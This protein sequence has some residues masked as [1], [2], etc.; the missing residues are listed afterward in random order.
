MQSPTRLYSSDLDRKNSVERNPLSGSETPISDTSFDFDEDL[1]EQLNKSD[2]E[3][4]PDSEFYYKPDQ[5]E[6]KT[7]EI[8]QKIMFNALSK[9]E[10]G[11][12]ENF[13]Y[14]NENVETPN[15]PGQIETGESTKAFMEDVDNFL[16]DLEK[17]IKQF[18]EEIGKSDQDQEETDE[19]LKKV[20][21]SLKTVSSL[22]QSQDGSI[23]YI[24]CENFPL[25]IK[26]DKTEKRCK[27]LNHK[28]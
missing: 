20:L 26:Y 2:S 10:E 22:S 9:T 8:E 24:S 11:H 13:N 6:Y 25:L 15:Q 3:E 28:A 4:K 16:A 18:D 14:E 19:Q 23:W 21:I 12:I 17:T 7:F 1:L 27:I 5:K